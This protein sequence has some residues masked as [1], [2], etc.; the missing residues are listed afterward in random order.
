MGI[1]DGVSPMRLAGRRLH[2]SRSR[3]KCE[4]MSV[5]AA[6]LCLTPPSWDDP[7]VVALA[8][9]RCRVINGIPC[10]GPG[11]DCDADNCKIIGAIVREFMLAGEARK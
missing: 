5:T 3:A 2:D 9:E 8:K 4:G 7:R 6:H 11:N 10:D 1:M